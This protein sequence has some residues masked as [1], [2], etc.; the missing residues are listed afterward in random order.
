MQGI[1][2]S[3]P[4]AITF[5]V[6]TPGGSAIQRIPLPGA[7]PGEPTVLGLPSTG[8]YSLLQYST[9]CANADE[10]IVQVCNPTALPITAPEAVFT[11]THFAF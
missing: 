7:V 3:G 9:Y 8:P 4:V 10:V 6:V 2:Y 5:G 1:L 11:V